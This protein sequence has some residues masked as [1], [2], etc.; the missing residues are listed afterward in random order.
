MAARMNVLVAQ[1]RR[2]TNP[3]FV[4][5]TRELYQAF[6]HE[7]RT[8]GV[9]ENDEL[10]QPG[11]PKYAPHAR[12]R[13]ALIDTLLKPEYTHVLWLDLDIVNAPADLIE[14][15]ARVSEDAIVAPLVY[16]ERHDETAPPSDENG[17]WFYDIGGFVYRGEW[18]HKWQPQWLNGS[19]VVELD[20]VGCCYL[21]PADVYRNGARYSAWS[22]RVE[23]ERFNR[24]ARAMGYRVLVDTT[25]RVEHAYLPDY[26]ERWP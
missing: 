24:E 13:N 4:K 7:P 6:T 26:G 1:P 20:S 19:D 2:T 15:L 18:T 23:H 11:E 10:L 3:H 16:V 9:F 17:G 8:F 12:A 14:R 5:R 21:V 22:R 25:T